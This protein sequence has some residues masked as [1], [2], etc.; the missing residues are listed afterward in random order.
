MLGKSE[1]RRE[2]DGLQFGLENSGGAVEGTNPM[3]T[4]FYIFSLETLFL[5]LG[6]LPAWTD[7]GVQRPGS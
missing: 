2:A 5:L 7:P 1:Q 3:S 4:S 6:C